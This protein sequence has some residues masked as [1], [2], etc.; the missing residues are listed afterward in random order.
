M[1]EVKSSLASITFLKVTRTA[2]ERTIVQT[3]VH[4]PGALKV[5]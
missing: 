5:E 2:K 3:S 1:G 4:V